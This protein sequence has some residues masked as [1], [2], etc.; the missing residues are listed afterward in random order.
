M[1]LMKAN[2]NYPLQRTEGHM[3]IRDEI[4]KLWEKLARDEDQD[5]EL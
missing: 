5:G 2:R 1:L 4:Y 3:A